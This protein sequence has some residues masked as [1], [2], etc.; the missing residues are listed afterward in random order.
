MEDLRLMAKILIKAGAELD[1]P[2]RDELRGDIH[3][4][5]ADVMAAESER[6]RA[7][8]RGFLPIR[9][10][11]QPGGKT[12]FL[13]DAVPESGYVFNVKLLSLQLASAGTVLVYIASS[14]PSTGSTPGRL[15]GNLSTSSANQVI[16]WSSSQLLL[17]AD[18]ALYLVATQAINVYFLIAMQVPAEM[19][20]KVYD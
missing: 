16:T 1:I 15:V 11:G 4:A 14:T 2:T 7:R 8:A 3:G 17:F 10:Y 18:E 5:V 12:T 19:V 13:L 6:Q 20:Y 9:L